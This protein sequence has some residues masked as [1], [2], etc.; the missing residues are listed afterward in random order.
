MKINELANRLNVSRQFIHLLDRG[1]RKLSAEK[2]SILDS[3]IHELS[4]CKQSVDV[5][6]KRVSDILDIKESIEKIEYRLS[7]V[8]TLLLELIANIKNR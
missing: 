3:I 2:E 6:S 8:E 1:H 4:D 5:S 7:T